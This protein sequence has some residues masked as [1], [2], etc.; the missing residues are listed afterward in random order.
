L[1]NCIN[2]TILNVIKYLEELGAK[3]LYPFKHGQFSMKE[4]DVELSFDIEQFNLLIDKNN[5]WCPIDESISYNNWITIV[6]KHLLETLQGFYKSLLPI[7]ENK[8]NPLN[9]YINNYNNINYCKY[10]FSLCF[11]KTFYHI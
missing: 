3:V 2:F 4:L 7:A 9:K 5:I 1:F 10:Y 6:T 8:V 11:V